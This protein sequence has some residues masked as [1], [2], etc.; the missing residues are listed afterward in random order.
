M[1]V[2]CPENN[3]Q[4]VKLNTDMLNFDTSV[5]SIQGKSGKVQ[6]NS[7]SPYVGYSG[8]KYIIKLSQMSRECRQD[9]FP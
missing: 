3:K 7:L 8:G 9:D 4:D 1:F 5:E 2:L 6:I